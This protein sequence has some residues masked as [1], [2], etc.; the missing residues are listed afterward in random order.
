MKENNNYE[1]PPLLQRAY[2]NLFQVSINLSFQ[3]PSIPALL[4]SDA[5]HL[6]QA[7]ETG[8]KAYLEYNGID[9]DYT[10]DISDLLNTAFKNN[11]YVPLTSY[12]HENPEVLTVWESKSRYGNTFSVDEK[13][14]RRI[15]KE[16]VES[17]DNIEKEFIEDFN[18]L[19]NINDEGMER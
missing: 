18:K 14:I 16:A 5:Y 2:D 1:R 13:R 3:D 17:I 7:I 8:I 11:L 6:S 10:H 12:F 4:R 19:K 9:Y 15:Y